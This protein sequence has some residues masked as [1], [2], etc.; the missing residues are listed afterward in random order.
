[1]HVTEL[2]RETALAVAKAYLSRRGYGIVDEGGFASGNGRVDL[3]VK[4]ESGIHLV[5]VV[6]CMVDGRSLWEC[7][8]RDDLERISVDYLERSLSTERITA[9]TVEVAAVGSDRA[10]VRHSVFVFDGEE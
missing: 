6:G 7:P 8:G 3:V 4:G 2:D 1:M 9:G 10:L 5:A